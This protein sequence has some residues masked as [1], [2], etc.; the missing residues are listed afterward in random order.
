[1]GGKIDDAF[2]SLK[3]GSGEASS[4]GGYTSQLATFPSGT[5]PADPF[6]NAA[7]VFLYGQ[8]TRRYVQASARS[9]VFKPA[10]CSARCPL[11]AAA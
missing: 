9:Y 11:Q 3:P 8:R 7:S 10:R 2:A 5:S 6:G 4:S 1:M